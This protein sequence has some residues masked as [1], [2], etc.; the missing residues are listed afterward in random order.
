MLASL[1]CIKRLRSSMHRS[2]T[3]FVSR[4]RLS[5]DPPGRQNAALPS[6]FKSQCG[7]SSLNT[8]AYANDCVSEFLQS[9][10]AS[11][12]RNRGRSG[13]LRPESSHSQSS[14]KST[15]HQAPERCINGSASV[16]LAEKRH[17]TL[18]SLRERLAEC[19]AGWDRRS[20]P[21]GPGAAA[22]HSGT[23]TLS[24]CGRRHSGC[25]NHCQCAGGTVTHRDVGLPSD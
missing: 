1:R 12:L 25:H 16:A 17:G 5:C 20:W 15:C 21:P 7:F 19:A 18:A 9:E 6:A 10:W 22:D 23:A 3:K 14:D 4:C 13:C 11:E 8:P 24:H 2:A